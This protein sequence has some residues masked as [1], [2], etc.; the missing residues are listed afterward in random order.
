MSR[1]FN[2]TS[3]VQSC[4]SLVAASAALLG[5]D[6]ARA[7][8]KTFAA[9]FLVQ[10][11]GAVAVGRGET[12]VADSTLGT[13][14]MWWNPAGLARM[15]KR[16]FAVHY[17]QTLFSNN[18]TLA[19]ASPSSALGTIAV[20]GH[21]VNYG[22]I[23]NTEGG[24]GTETGISTNRYYVLI[25][26]YATPVGK[27]LSF[28]L[29]AKNIR[30]S[31]VECSGCENNE[32]GNT[33]AID[34]GAQYIVP[35]KFP[36]SLGA[37]VRNLGPKLQIRDAPQA[38]PLPRVIQAGVQAKLPIA[39]LEMNKTALQVMSDVFL[40]PAYTSPSIRFGA[41]LTYHELYSLRAG[42]KYLSAT[43]GNE[44]GFTVGV[45]LKYNT[46]QVNLAR[47]FDSSSNSGEVGAPTY[48]SLR[49]VF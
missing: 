26:S 1:R 25:A 12:T 13:E 41:D 46:L 37:S 9:P 48:V 47:R 49:F 3:L 43:D 38:D 16:E 15:R 30:K 45:G 35:A 22:D 18:L 17:S 34:F 5:A 20:L 23:P 40:S 8:V 7:Q 28:G 42:Y 11:L 36:V 2:R 39:A 29:S 33:S 4:A 19:Y 10:P 32:V 21:I 14:A 27:R 44:G 24:S 6:V 31:F